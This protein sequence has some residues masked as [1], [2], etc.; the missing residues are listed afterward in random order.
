MQSESFEFALQ[1]ADTIG[2]D[3]YNSISEQ[4]NSKTY[5]STGN[6]FYQNAYFSRKAFGEWPESENIFLNMQQEL[7]TLSV[8]RAFFSIIRPKC[9]Q[10]IDNISNQN[11]ERFDV[12]GLSIASSQITASLALGKLIKLRFP[13]KIIIIGGSVIHEDMAIE[14][15]SH[16][17]W[18]DVA[19][20]GEADHSLP[21]FLQLTHNK[22]DISTINGLI[23]RE[24]GNIIYTGKVSP[25]NIDNCIIPNYSKYF[26]SLS[27]RTPDIQ[28]ITRAVH[29]ELSRGCQ[30]GYKDSCSFCSDAHSVPRARSASNA[31]SA[32][33]QIQNQYPL[34][35]YVCM[36]D[37]SVS[38]HHIHQVFNQYGPKIIN[39]PILLNSKPWLSRNDVRILKNA[40]IICMRLGIE[41]LHPGILKLLN[42]KQSVIR[43]LSNL[44]WGRCYD[45]A[46]EW[47]LLI[48]TPQEKPE[49]SHQMANMIPQ[50]RHFNPPVA[51]PVSITKRSPYFNQKET[52]NNFRLHHL[53]K[54]IYPPW[55][56][57]DN[58]AWKY[59]YDDEYYQGNV[60]ELAP[61]HQKLL[62]AIQCWTD[63][64][65]AELI[66]NGEN[67]ILDSR[68]ETTK[69]LNITDIERKRIVLCDDIQSEQTI[70]KKFGDVSSIIKQ[71]TEQSLLFKEQDK[72]LGLPTVSDEELFNY[73]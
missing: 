14:L 7:D 26:Q 60:K 8:P 1:L 37:R 13:Q 63:I 67:Q 71:L 32:L 20:I 61:H 30:Y 59:Q 41:S 33:K 44:K 43:S 29:I 56:D 3:N 57:L 73:A 24:N 4:L 64:K 51:I 47:H 49:W 21:Q 25:A 50:I 22:Q 72:Y 69:V 52:F 34:A 66:F 36:T 40:N 38:K 68:L 18:I 16:L 70:I 39:K 53:Y 45:I 23:Y 5:H 62:D 2:I 54:Y 35:S 46:I 65:N 31:I 42:K 19:F 10:F 48:R 11:W 12:I 55:I 9:E 58:V 27:R 17:K 15:M 28:N 6:Y